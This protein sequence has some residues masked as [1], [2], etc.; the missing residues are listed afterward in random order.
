MLV[1]ELLGVEF[2]TPSRLLTLGLGS[3]LLPALFTLTTAGSLVLARPGLGSLMLGTLLM[4][5]AGVALLETRSMSRCEE[6]LWITLLELDLSTDLST[7][8]F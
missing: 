5:T 7:E 4:V 8:G 3:L 1:L 2:L 6:D